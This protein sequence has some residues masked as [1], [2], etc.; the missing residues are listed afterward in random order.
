MQRTSCT[1]QE[2]WQIFML[3]RDA[4][5]V[6][7]SDASMY[8]FQFH[9]IIFLYRTVYAVNEVLLMPRL[10]EIS[11]S[12]GVRMSPEISAECTAGRIFRVLFGRAVC[13]A[14]QRELLCVFVPQQTHVGVRKAL[15]MLHGIML[16]WGLA[17][18]K[19]YSLWEMRGDAPTHFLN[20]NAYFEC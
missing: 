17:T 9:L 10:N 1:R 20:E 19:R 16:S 7:W 14:H 8:S 13:A 11:R 6:A 5:H 2:M 3:H 12:N 18:A 15:L 4:E